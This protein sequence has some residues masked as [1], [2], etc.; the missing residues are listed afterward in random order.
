MFG[1]ILGIIRGG[2]NSHRHKSG[3]ENQRAKQKYQQ[4]HTD[5]STPIAGAVSAERSCEGECHGLE[6]DRLTRSAT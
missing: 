1:G 5:E 2:S 6:N 3:A 4:D